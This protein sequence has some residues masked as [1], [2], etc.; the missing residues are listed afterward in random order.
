ME[1]KVTGSATAGRWVPLPLD[2][3][4]D[5]YNVTSSGVLALLGSWILLIAVSIGSVM[6]ISPSEFLLL[7]SGQ[8]SINQFFFF[9]PPLIIGT[10]L[11]FWV[12]FEWGFIP[13]F[14]SG[15]V[16][17]FSASVTYY[18]GLLFGIA[19]VLGLGIYGLVYYCVPFDPALR[20]LKSIA[21]F[22]VISF[23]AAIAS[24]LGSFVWSDFF[25]LSTVQTITL[26]KGW[27]T[28]M[29]LQSMVIVAP[30]LYLFT[31]R[32]VAYRKKVFPRLP[33]PTV[34][35]GW[36][37][38]AIGSV[39]VVLVLFII[40]A[41]VLGTETLYQQMQTMDAGVSKKLIQSNA[42]LEIIS[43]ISIGLVLVLGSGSIYLVGSWNKNLQDEVER[44]TEQLVRSQNKLEEALNER[45][46][47]LDTIHDRVR[48]N[49]TMVLAL[50]ELQL[51]GN[52]EKSNKEILKDSHSRI[53]SMALIHET[54][55]QAK[56]FERV[57]LKNF[58]IKLS[59]RLQKSF[60]SSTQNIEVS[61]NAEEVEVH[62]DRGVPIA[63]ILN[64]LMVNAFMHG[65]TDMSKG[66]VFVCIEK[67]DDRLHLEVR[68]NGHPLPPDFEDIT[69]KTLGYK[70]IRTLVK[71]LQGELKILNK[72]KS[73]IRVLVPLE[74]LEARS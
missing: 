34:T 3:V 17:T 24:S 39:A 54:M 49:L 10:L 53:R 69:K 18:W 64:E 21:F 28:G 36:I 32:V 33:K 43:W 38:S 30:L 50:L 56:S 44:K 70:L 60:E 2:Y 15:F 8:T 35:L 22:T 29:F 16:I 1:N 72:E 40:G 65:F 37:Y 68:D 48:N 55:V 62:I 71:Q 13:L 66:V 23:F 67:W 12:G 5:K 59:N 63:M 26:W 58:A 41:K 4:L 47:L 31:P 74:M 51:K 45:D 11:L 73:A 19:F 25:G 57:N 9:Y 27:W 61:M 7:D 46:L 52:K 42:S 20:D 6:W 14:L